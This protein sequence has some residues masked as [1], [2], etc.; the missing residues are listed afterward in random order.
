[1]ADALGRGSPGMCSKAT[2]A[3]R[4]VG[5]ATLLGGGIQPREARGEA[6]ITLGIPCVVPPDGPPTLGARLRSTPEVLGVA[7]LPEYS[8]RLYRFSPIFQIP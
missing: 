7:L 3:V 6:T 1:M 5:R 8:G 2:Q 4:I